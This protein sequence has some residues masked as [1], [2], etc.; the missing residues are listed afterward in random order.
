MIICASLPV[1]HDNLCFVANDTWW[2]LFRY[3][4]YMIIS[5]SCITGN[6]TEIIMYHWQRN[7]DYHVSLAT[8]HRLSCITGNETQII[9]YHWQ[10][11]RDY[12]VSLAAKQRLS[13]FT[14]HT[15]EATQQD[16]IQ[17]TVHHVSASARTIILVFLTYTHINATWKQFLWLWSSEWGKT[18]LFLARSIN[19]GENL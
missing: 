9:M 15:T 2:S 16:I 12:H 19:L 14:L 6:K 1:I 10:R 13:S 11:N 7:R 8:K 18:V 3:Q 5:V 4:W 17:L